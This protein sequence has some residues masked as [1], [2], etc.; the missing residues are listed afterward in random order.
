MPTVTLATLESMRS[1]LV[2]SKYYLN[3]QSGTMAPVTLHCSYGDTGRSVSFYIFD[4]GDEFDLTGSTVSLHGTRHDGASFGPISC[5]VSDTNKV[6]FSLTTSVTGAEGGG[7]AEFTITKNGTTIGSTNFGIMVE[8]CAFPNG[9]AYDT[10]PSVYMDILHYVQSTCSTLQNY[11]DSSVS[12]I[13]TYVDST[14]IPEEAIT[15]DTT[16]KIS[17]AAADSKA[18]GDRLIPSD[19]LICGL[20]GFDNAL[21]LEPEIGAVN[22]NVGATPTIGT[23][24]Y[25]VHFYIPVN[26]G[27]RFNISTIIPD[28]ESSARSTFY[29][30]VYLGSDGKILEKGMLAS[31]FSEYNIVENHQ[32]IVP[33]NAVLMIVLAY[34]NLNNYKKYVRISKDSFDYSTGTIKALI[35]NPKKYTEEDITVTPITGSVQ[36]SVNIGSLISYNSISWWSHAIIPVNPGEIYK[37]DT[38]VNYTVADSAWLIYWTDASG[39]VLSR[40]LPID[41]GGRG[42][43]TYSVSWRAVRDYFV[44]APAGATQLVVVAE[45]ANTTFTT[46][47]SVKRIKVSSLQDQLDMANGDYLPEYYYA[48]DYWNTVLGKI[49]TKTKSLLNGVSFAFMTDPHF[50]SNSLNSKYMIKSVLNNTRVPF[51]ICGGDFPAAYG[52]SSDLDYSVDILEEYQRFVGF[53]KFFTVRGNHDFTIKTNS[54]YTTGAENSGV[55]KNIGYTYDA[56]SRNQERYLYG[57]DPTNMAW[58]I[59]IPIQKTRII[60]LN[61]CDVAS[62]DSTKS[63]DVSYHVRREQVDWLLD[64]GLAKE[65]YRYIFLSHIPADSSLTSHS[66]TQYVFHE[67]FKAMKNKTTLSYTDTYN[68][69]VG[70]VTHDFT[71]TTS[72]PICHITGHCHT[73]QSNV[74]NN[75]LSITTTCDAHY[76]DDGYGATDKT[77]TEQAFDVFVINYD[78]GKIDAIRCGRG[79]DRNWSY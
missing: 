44:S 75:F 43:N 79:N 53:D 30:T 46:Y 57:S 78:T 18:V 1:E 28:L 25:I 67:I 52:D 42:D 40:D 56:I 47:A 27:D 74:D 3:V 6:T 9:V 60:G 5:T 17:G 63:W 65:G 8:D 58:Y 26:G 10:D 22:G 64:V 2:S 45:L 11:V 21:F 73:D 71:S 31:D 48:D 35:G 66:P 55:T 34:T 69:G 38:R 39:I 20:S 49:N 51:C 33:S 19:N 14:V 16:L 72:V 41:I 7:I 36:T 54:S 37:I 61:S 76:A 15:I 62:V 32:I 50:K 70:T 29:C 68:D 59:D 23:Q 77:I 12:D 4:G 24:T 13:R